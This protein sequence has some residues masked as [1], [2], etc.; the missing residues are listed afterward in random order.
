MTLLDW[1]AAVV[2]AIELPIPL[3]WLTLHARVEFWRQHIRAAYLV[4]GISSWGVVGVFLY[5]FHA[6]L[7]DS[8][9]APTWAVAAGLALI[10][11]EGY[12]F[13]R[14]D[15]ELG[16]VRL[17]GKAELAGAGELATQGIYAR[18]R[19]PRYTGMMA[20]V[21]GAC[22]L[23]NSL[24]LWVVA[25]GWWLLALLSITWEERE[26]RARFGAAYVEYSKRVPRL[27]PFR[28]WPHKQ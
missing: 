19:H 4:V 3:F 7:F 5:A 2:L 16:A 25:A 13:Y 24:L 1:V 18:T 9:R 6:R 21:A 22:L 17:V 23:S 28:L 14:V 27:L 12:V 11:S 15:R 20:A 10:L 26:L 8:E